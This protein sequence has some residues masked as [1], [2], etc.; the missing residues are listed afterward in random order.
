MATSGSVNYTVTRD[1]IITEAL[2]QIG[3]LAEGESPSA[4]QLTSSARTLNMLVKS[5]QNVCKNLHVRQTLYLFQDGSTKTYTV[6]GSTARCVDLFD[7]T[8]VT[9]A[10]SSGASTIVVSSIGNIVANANIGI[11]LD[12]GTRQWTTVSGS[13]AGTTVTLAATLTDDVAAGNTVF[14]YT[15]LANKP[16]KIEH[17][18]VQN[19]STPTAPIDTS[20]EIANR[21]DYLEMSNKG[22]TGQA[23]LIYPDYQ[24]SSVKLSIW[25]VAA[26]VDDVI[27]M[28]VWR[29]IEDFDA[30]SNDADF[31]QHWYLALAY[32]LAVL[33]APKYGIPPS[34]YAQLRN[35]ADELQMDAEAH[36]VE[37]SITLVPNYTWTR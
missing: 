19:L 14:A 3:V 17:A 11:E 29:T 18:Y 20:I 12:D 4:N 22:T 6:D 10:A 35:T 36:E 28:S 23:T 24:L 9:T 27:T 33:L 26:S 13:P 30:A 31:P 34:I 21:S 37:E 32:R 15:T 7:A 25:P 2:E 5:L 8:T 16:L 1:D